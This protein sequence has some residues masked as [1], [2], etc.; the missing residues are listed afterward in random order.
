MPNTS[1]ACGIVTIVDSSPAKARTHPPGRWREWCSG[2]WTRTVIDRNA[3]ALIDRITRSLLE[4]L[5]LQTRAAL[6][7][8]EHAPAEEREA[9]LAQLAET[10]GR[11]VRLRAGTLG[12]TAPALVSTES[13][14]KP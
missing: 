13:H 4:Q 5:E 3:A 11:L 9:L 2:H 6:T 1:H 12:A 8:L 7:L 10:R 14:A